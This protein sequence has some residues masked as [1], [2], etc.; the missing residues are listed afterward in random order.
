MLPRLHFSI[1]TAYFSLSF[2]SPH[3]FPASQWKSGRSPKGAI[4]LHSSRIEPAQAPAFRGTYCSGEGHRQLKVGRPHLLLQD[5]ETWP[6]GPV[7]FLGIDR[8]SH[9]TYDPPSIDLLVSTA[10]SRK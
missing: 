10:N 3:S 8:P 1:V 4:V 2:L 6:S 7:E 5:E 9:S